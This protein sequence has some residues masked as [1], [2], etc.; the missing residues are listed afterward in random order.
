MKINRGIAVILA[1]A[2]FVCACGML[3]YAV[4]NLSLQDEMLPPD[5]P[6]RNE[7][8]S[9]HAPAI[10]MNTCLLIY[11]LFL[12]FGIVG[13]FYLIAM[14]RGREVMHAFFGAL[15]AVLILVGILYVMAVNNAQENA[16]ENLTT[17][18]TGNPG[19]TPLPNTSNTPP[20]ISMLL[21]A[22]MFV[23]IAV[24]IA[25]LLFS[26]LSTRTGKGAGKGKEFHLE[27]AKAIDEGI[28]FFET[29]VSARD[30]IIRCYRRMTEILATHGVKDALYL[31]P[32]EFREEVKLKMGF[33]SK[34]LDT[35]V[36]L[37]ETARYSSHQ[38]GDVEK[39]MALNALKGLRSEVGG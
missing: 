17:N 13:I 14:R 12:G 39:E 8:I 29:G 18:S 38:I 24:I 32:R 7:T 2:F 19:N 9:P 10:N 27:F 21:V 33:E 11:W 20:L 26:Y 3:G 37:F 16:G 1:F 28:A 4:L 22:G 35:L 6:Q 23:L 25:T 5:A 31:T 30:A 15:L 34:N 36:E